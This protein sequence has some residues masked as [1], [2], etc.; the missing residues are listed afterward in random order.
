MS[1]VSDYTRGVF[2]VSVPAQQGPATAVLTRRHDRLSEEAR[3]AW[4][5]LR[6]GGAW[7][8]PQELGEA[9]KA[10]ADGQQPAVKAGRWLSALLVRGHIARGK[11]LVRRIKRYGV[12]SV[13]IPIPGHTLEPSQS[14]DQPNESR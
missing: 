14:A 3:R 11:P 12:T 10:D 13:C 6:D 5:M 9:M 1:R 7:W 8:T 2:K 4:L